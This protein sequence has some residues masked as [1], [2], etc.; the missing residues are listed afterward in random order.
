ML[1]RYTPISDNGMLGKFLDSQGL[2]ENT[3]VL[4]YLAVAK[5]GEQPIDGITEFNP[6]G[7][8]ADAIMGYGC[9]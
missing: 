5:L 9:Q 7:L 2:A 4:L 1:L 8:T 6:D 3:Q